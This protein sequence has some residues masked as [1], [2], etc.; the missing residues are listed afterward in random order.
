M[1]KNFKFS[2]VNINKE[3]FADELNKKEAYYGNV[4]MWTVLFSLPLFWLFDFLFVRDEWSNLM[5]VRL[6]VTGISYFICTQGAKKRWTSLY[7]LTWFIFLNIILHSVICSIVPVGILLPYFLMLSIV[8]LLINTVLFWPPIYSIISSLVSYLVI[9][10]IFSKNDRTDKYN[11]LI[12]HGGGI[13]FVMSAFSCLVAYNRYQ[14]LKREIA[15]NIMIDAANNRLLEQN[16]KINDQKYVIEEANRKLKVLSDYRHNTLNIMLHDFRN[17]TGSIQMSLDLLKT[18]SDNLSVEQNEILTYIGAGNEKLNYL[19]EKLAASADKDEAKIEFNQEKF[20]INP[21]VENAVLDIA[22]AAQMKQINL[23]L[24]LSASP[25]EVYLDKLFMEQVLF[26]LLSN[27]IRYSR[28]D[29][30]VT[31]H[32]HNQNDNC[33]IEVINI[34]KLIGKEKMNDLFNKLQPSKS[35]IDST[36]LESEMG[37][38][39]A[40][41]ITEAMGG[42]F[43]YNSEES[44]GNYY[45]IEFDCTH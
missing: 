17:F 5:I 16:E 36:Q 12:A 24:H 15:K 7:T 39:V 14:I 27:V 42:R 35:L 3:E 11:I 44:T 37:F 22:D 9:I 23:Q 34:G 30:V 25:I 13:Y 4:V 2:Y 45:R 26:K 29:S 18:K 31:I 8:M 20:D 1:S 6:I 41:K 19:S 10:V 28:K 33:V 21:E 38:S 43:A 32:T 40:K